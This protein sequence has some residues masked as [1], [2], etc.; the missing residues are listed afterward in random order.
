MGYTPPAKEYN[1]LT[2]GTAQQ[3]I[4]NGQAP[5][6]SPLFVM[7]VS[8]NAYLGIWIAE[9]Q[10]VDQSGNAPQEIYYTTNLETQQWTL[11]G[12][13]GSYHT[14]S[15]YRWF[16]DSTS[17]TSSAIVGKSFRAYCSFGCSGGK[18]S[19]YVNIAIES[20]NPFQAIDTTKSYTIGAAGAF[21]TD[22][23]SKATS[24]AAGA[25]YTFKATGDGAYTIQ[26][27]S[28]GFLGVASTTTATRA[29]GTVPAI[30]TGSAGVGQQWWV[31]QSK[32]GATFRLVNRYS[33]LVLALSGTQGRLAETTPARSWD[34]NG[35]GV[36]GGRKAAE[37]EL[38]LT[39]A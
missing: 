6:T 18:S 35:S 4:A 31:I 17:K 39:A 15:W 23:A 37:Q 8:Y 12:N 34:S 3:Q 26:N 5:A 22:S 24:A 19:E 9:P 11:L 38:V 1:P 13:T 20:S 36:G 29:W 10:A 7:D 2:Q 30:S 25:K 33:G 32:G 14:A 28:G 21:L 27:A 16:L